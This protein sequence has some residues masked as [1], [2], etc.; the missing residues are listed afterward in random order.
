MSINSVCF[1]Q[2]ADTAYTTILKTGHMILG[3]G[4]FVNGIFFSPKTQID[5]KLNSSTYFCECLKRYYF[6]DHLKLSEE[7]F[8]KLKIK[9]RNI[10]KDTAWYTYHYRNKDTTDCIEYVELSLKTT[11]PIELNDTTLKVGE[12]EEILKEIQ[13]DDII[14]VKRRSSLFRRDKIKITTNSVK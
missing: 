3:S 2:E 9:K 7:F 5:N 12:R 14:K 8:L 4:Y 6:L 11:L 10:I 13:Q 1:G